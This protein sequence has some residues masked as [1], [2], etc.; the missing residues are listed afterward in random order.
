MISTLSKLIEK[1]INK[2][3]IW[4]LESSKFITKEQCGF[5]K[6]HSTIDALTTLHTD[7]CSAFRRNQHLIT[8][9]LDISKAYDTVWKK[10]VLTILYSWKINGNLFN[11]IK[12][13]LTDR[14]FNVKIYDKISST[15]S[16]DNGLP[17]G[18]V[19]SVTLFLVAINDI[20]KNLPSPVKYIL[21]A[22]DCNIYCSGTQIKTTTHFLQL[23]LDSLSKWS[24]K[25]GFSFSPAKTQC[26]IFNKKKNDPQPAINF[27]NTQLSF[28]NSIRILGLTFDSKLTWRP[29]LKKLKTECQSRLRTIKILGNSTWGSDTKSLITIYKALILSLID[30]G[31]IIFNSAKKKDLNTLDPIHNQGI[32]L[33]IGAFRTSPV[34]SILFYAG[35]PP[36]Q[37]R[38][39]SHILKYVTKIKNL[40]NYITENIIH[41]TLP[42]N[43]LPS[44]NTVFENFKIISNNL[45]FQSQSLNKILPP[46]PPW[47]WSPKINTQLAEY[48]KH[49]TDSRI[50]L[51][52]FAEIMSQQY[53]NYTQIYTDA[54]KSKNGVGFAVITDWENHLF[55]LPSSF[56][57]YTAE[58]HAIYQALLIISTSNPTNCHIIISDSLS[59]LTAISNPYPKNELIQH[60]QKLIS[61]INSPTCF[62]WV[63][64]HIGIPGNEKADTSAHEAI[65]SPQSIKISSSPSSEIFGTIHQKIMEEWQLFWEN[66]PLTNKL[67]NTKLLVK[68]LNYPPGTKRKDEVTVTRAKIGHSLT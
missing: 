38:R 32:R 9:A 51:N 52:C 49:S 18:S 26:I 61:E 67:R 12:N 53:P 10:R 48:C 14:T 39:H 4:F 37:Y 54:S 46:L 8:I 25:T 31:D 23:A 40:T 57:I 58:T 62:M 27:L 5:R 35:E 22:D 34:D 16:I 42:T 19:L 24:H 17:Q 30:Y 59:A 66:I 3:L 33:A 2:R 36:L 15:H 68:K 29:H 64:S 44:R 50:I 65:T 55:K 45:D 47:L 20:Y 63:P 6:N 13:F 21:F 41:S 11:F 1:I 43:I 7:I 60:I 56:S 28:T